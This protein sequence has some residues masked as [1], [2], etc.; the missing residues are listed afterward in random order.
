MQEFISKIKENYKEGQIIFI[1]DIL[2][3]FPNLTR[4]YV[5]CLLKEAEDKKEIVKFSHGIYCIPKK[6]F[7]GY[8]SLTP[9][10]VV[11]NKYIINNEDVLGIYG[12]LTLLNEFNISSQ[13]PNTLEIIT[14]N[15]ATRKRYID[16]A[17]MKFILRKSRFEIT[18][19]NYKYYQILQLFLE[20]GSAPI[21]TDFT[22]ERI[23]EF[24]KN[25]NIDQ[26]K[27]IKYSLNF[28]AKV[29][30]NLIESEVLNGII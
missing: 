21:L 22:K 30:K 3:L 17:G 25:N 20:I 24:I 10:K 1:K 5:F 12:G 2:L 27:L 14:N 4:A 26:N 29:T 18:K 23:K 19:D 7:F 13:I 16:I 8:T 9:I 28:T 11:R 6:T 15:E